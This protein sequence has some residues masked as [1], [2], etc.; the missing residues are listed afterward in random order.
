ML[1]RSPGKQQQVSQSTRT[2]RNE[3]PGCMLGCYHEE[4]FM[5]RGGG[6]ADFSTSRVGL[7]APTPHALPNSPPS[8]IRAT[9][10]TT[11]VEV[12]ESGSVRGERLVVEVWCS[13]RVVTRGARQREASTPVPN[14][15]EATVDHTEQ[16]GAGKERQNTGVR[17]HH[18][19]TNGVLA[20]ASHLKGRRH[21]PVNCFAT[22]L[23]SAILDR[24]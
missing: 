23:M 3:N 2:T 7:L 1:S 12:L 19:M 16:R 24:L 4:G 22:A 20:L 18:S 5:A 9:E 8:L 17:S 6:P 21:A 13:N 14:D 10:E 11:H 15:Q